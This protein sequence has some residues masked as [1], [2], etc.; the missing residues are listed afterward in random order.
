MLDMQFMLSVVDYDAGF[1]R[2]DAFLNSC[3]DLLAKLC[4]LCDDFIGVFSGCGF[5]I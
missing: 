3:R 4:S 1:V 5:A 2:S